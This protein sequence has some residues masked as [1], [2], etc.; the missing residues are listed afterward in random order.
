MIKKTILVSA[1][2]GLLMVVLFGYDAA[3]YISTSYNRVT[4][5]VRSNVPVEFQIDRARTMVK[6]LEPE[7]RR[8]MHVIAK[9]EVEVN[10]LTEQI[11]NAAI[12]G[13]KD[14]DEV[15]RLQADLSA[16]KSRYHYAGRSYTVT[17]VKQDLGRRFERYKTATA[18]LESLRDMRDARQRNLEAAQKKLTA[19]VASERQLRVEVENLEAKLKL[20]EVAET[21]SDFNFDD[22]KLA[23]AK[24]LISQIRTDLDVTAK[25]ANADV[26]YHGEI[27]LDEESPD[28]IEQTVAAYFGLDVPAETEFAKASYEVE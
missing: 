7:I 1:G 11:E 25:L 21:S 2:V 15:L 17:E 18:T 23:R 14:K 16:N 26:N 6:N 13:E 19:M 24:E 22:S 28:D 3:S 12:K 8:C 5:S 9:E 27:V 4:E 20:V 10:K